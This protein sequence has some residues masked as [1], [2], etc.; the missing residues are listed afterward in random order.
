[1][2]DLNSNFE[3]NKKFY[4][5]VNYVLLFLLTVRLLAM[6][7]IP[8]MDSTEARYGEIAREMLIS[9][10]WV[11][12]FHDYGSP[13]L[14][15]PP[16]STWLA[17]GSMYLFGINELAVRLPSLI[18]SIGTIFLVWFIAKKNKGHLVATFACLIL[19]GCLYFYLNAG[20]VMTD[21]ALLFCTSL[22]MISFWQ[23]LKSN[24]RRWGYLFFVSLGLGLLAK[25]PV[26]I[27][28]PAMPIFIWVL[29][30]QKL[31]LTITQLPW[32]TGGLITLAIAL[33][34]YILAEL[35][36][37]GFLNYF[38]IGEHFNRFYIP[39][40][41]GNKYGFS[42]AKP[43]GMVW[44][45]ALVGFLPWTFCIL[46]WSIKQRKKLSSVFFQNDQG[47][48]SYLL[49]WM[50]IPLI[51]FTFSKNIIYTYV[52]PSLPAFALIFAE[53][54][55]RTGITQK[56]TYTILYLSASCGFVFLFIMLTTLYFPPQLALKSQKSIITSWKKHDP[57]QTSKL[58]YWTTHL[59]YSAQFYSNGH[60]LATLDLKELQD[61]IASNLTS[62][63][64]IDAKDYQQTPLHYAK[65][66]KQVDSIQVAEH[67]M[68]LLEKKVAGNGKLAT[69]AQ[70]PSS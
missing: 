59:D 4:L 22:T 30:H 45:Y 14:A 39:A 46:H 54:W 34:W 37:P 32:L 43:Y 58:I 16:L 28:L 52:F 5:K 53:L 31:R 21:S 35:H 63:V 8:L 56:S 61:I 11:T 23:C 1:M 13:F 6:Y 69:P 29:I 50:I 18:L 12:L 67:T 38:I 70:S 2:D 27:V 9:A 33:P 64:I 7:F 40:W 17:A 62:F 10:N 68:L 15:K 3:F 51:F 57:L 44:I 41:N 60:A 19:A 49:L 26:A 25:G 66:L 36:T 65:Y 47:W 48:L 55:H 24:S 20:A 42:H